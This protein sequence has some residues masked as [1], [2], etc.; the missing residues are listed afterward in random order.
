MQNRGRSFDVHAGPHHHKV[1]NEA[2]FRDIF[3]QITSNHYTLQTSPEKN[4]KRAKLWRAFLF[5]QRALRSRET[6]GE[7]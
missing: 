3:V 4:G 6:A 7:A 2:L 1:T 5:L